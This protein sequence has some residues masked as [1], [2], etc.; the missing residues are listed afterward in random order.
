[1]RRN[2]VEGIRPKPAQRTSLVWCVAGSDGQT[3]MPV[4]NLDEFLILDE[5]KVTHDIIDFNSTVI[6]ASKK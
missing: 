3:I 6:C 4:S 1:M 5:L 2:V